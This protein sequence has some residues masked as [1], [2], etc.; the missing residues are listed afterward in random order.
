MRRYRFG[1]RAFDFM[2]GVEQQ[3]R[4]RLT[5]RRTGCLHT[6]VSPQRS[7]DPL[8]PDQSRHYQHQEQRREPMPDPKQNHRRYGSSRYPNGKDEPEEGGESEDG[9]DAEHLVDDRRSTCGGW[10]GGEGYASMSGIV[11]EAG[12]RIEEDGAGEEEGSV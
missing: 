3:P 4:K 10:R 11:D 9:S 5:E 8:G 1:G 2:L 6:L 12:E 7:T